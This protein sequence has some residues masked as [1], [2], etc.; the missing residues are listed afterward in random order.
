MQLKVRNPTF[1]ISVLEIQAKRALIIRKIWTRFVSYNGE[2][3]F[4]FF[5]TRD[6]KKIKIVDFISGNNSILKNE[7]VR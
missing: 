7:D 4:Q 6:L 1:K 2:F 5:A 3:I